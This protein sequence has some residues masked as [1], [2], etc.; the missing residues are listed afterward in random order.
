MTTT[1]ATC[2]APV[3]LKLQAVLAVVLLGILSVSPGVLG[4]SRHH[5]A[6]LL[7]TGFAVLG[8][9]L[10]F[11]TDCQVGLWRK[12]PMSLLVMAKLGWLPVII[13][14]AWLFFCD[15]GAFSWV[16]IVLDLAIFIRTHLY[17]PVQE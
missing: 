1:S 14:V 9:G 5:G 7:A 17:Q 4:Y 11:I 13:A 3:S 6:T 8:M 12:L 15:A 16:V 2:Y 10:N